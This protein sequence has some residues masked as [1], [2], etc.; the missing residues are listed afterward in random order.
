MVYDEN[1]K[2]LR[3]V[4]IMVNAVINETVQLAY[5]CGE[6]NR[7]I[8]EYDNNL[9]MEFI[10]QVRE[11]YVRDIIASLQLNKRNANIQSVL[12][13]RSADARF[14]MFEFEKHLIEKGYETV[15]YVR[16]LP[17]TEEGR[18]SLEKRASDLGLKEYTLAQY[19]NIIIYTK[20]LQ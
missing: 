5:D 6:G 9:D 15:S 2:P 14:F 7:V 16:T 17:E 4:V 20:R 13:D 1:N 18:K 8:I 11:N 10:A 3:R 12:Y 19:H